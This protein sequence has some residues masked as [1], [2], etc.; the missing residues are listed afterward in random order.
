MQTSADVLYLDSSALVKLVNQEPESEALGRFLDAQRD[1]TRVSS[2]LARVEVLRAARARGPRMVARARLLL[3][4]MRLLGLY[5]EILDAA[6]ELDGPGLR[7]LDA[8]HLAS[9]LALGS[10]LSAVVTYDRR[11]A[12]AAE[13]LG[14]AV[15]APGSG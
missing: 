12:G 9:A 7:S 11:M 3:D 6:A 10:A 15:V 13:R 8:I 1:R 14:L 4:D 5:D 2:R